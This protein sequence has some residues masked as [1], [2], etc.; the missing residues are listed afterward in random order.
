[1]FTFRQFTINDDITAMKVG[2]DGV[3]LGAWAS[4]GNS[5][6]D[7]GTGT[8]IIALMM[9]QR[10]PSACIT[11][12][13]IDEAACQQAKANINATTFKDR[14]ETR[15]I[16]LQQLADEATEGQYDAIVCNPPYFQNSLKSPYKQRNMARH[17]DTLSCREL[18]KSS[19]KL[20]KPTGTLC[21]IAPC[22]LKDDFDSEAVFCGMTPKQTVIIKTSPKKRPK[23]F[24]A[25]Y[26]TQFVTSPEEETQCL[27]DGN[28]NRT[29]WY[30]KLT[31]E[32]YL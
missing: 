31:G 7:A 18:M 20:L 13:D 32:F 15:K 22:D 21:I 19:Q 30:S 3:L 14:I 17:A 28:G 23:R 6:L 5:I 16:S 8:G 29:E 25:E 27:T 9:A 1:M 4:G 2:T 12:V 11:A 10:F 26:S 24:M